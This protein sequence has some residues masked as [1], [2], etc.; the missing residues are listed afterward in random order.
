[1]KGYRHLTLFDRE[2]L[3][4]LANQGFTHQ[5]IADQIGFS[6]SSVSREL[7]RNRSL[8][9]RIYEPEMA[10]IKSMNRKKRGCKIDKNQDFKEHIQEK[11][12]LGWAPDVIAK[13]FLLENDQSCISHETIYSWLYKPPQKKLKLYKMLA[14][15]KS[16]RGPR[17]TY[18]PKSHK[19]AD[20]ISIH[21]RPEAINNR[22]EFGHWEGDL[23]IGKYHKSQILTMQERKSRF[24]FIGKIP[25]KQAL[26]VSAKIEEIAK[27][28]KLS[29]I[30]PFYSLTLDNGTEFSEFKHL[31]KAL[32]I[33]VYFCDPYA[34][35]QKGGIEN[36]NGIIRRTIPKKSDMNHYS[37]NDINDLMWSINTIPRKC[38]GYKTP[39]EVIAKQEL[40]LSKIQKSRDGNYAL[41][42]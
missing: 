11:L 12:Q 23:V 19:I 20:K 25:S 1:M 21:T 39:Y 37:D 42:I 38:L 14:R 3:I 36:A 24:I 22:S 16:K 27:K 6:Q 28:L 7:K 4:I 17:K 2:K 40:C 15:Q 30:I 8:T 31:Q 5:L 41:A 34:S 32:G 10:Q 33:D 18:E 35:W 13:R 26:V 29:E 9:T